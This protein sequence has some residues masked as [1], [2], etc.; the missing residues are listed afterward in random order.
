[1]LQ[2]A[3][4]GRILFCTPALNTSP[5]ATPCRLAPRSHSERCVSNSASA[6]GNCFTL[7]TLVMILCALTEVASSHRLTNARQASAPF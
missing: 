1:M 6:P 7:R 2:G 4:C 3:S 5:D